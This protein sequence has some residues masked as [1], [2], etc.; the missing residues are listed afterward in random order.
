[1][2]NR[3]PRRS[4]SD[5]KDKPKPGFPLSIDVEKSRA[6]YGM[7]INRPMSPAYKAASPSHKVDVPHGVESGTD[8]SDG[9]H[10]PSAKERT[11]TLSLPSKDK[12]AK[13]RRR[14]VQL[15]PNTKQSPFQEEPGETSLLSSAG[16]VDSEDESSPVERMSRS[17]FIAPA[18]PAIRFSVSGN[19]FQELLSQVDPRNRSSLNVIK[20][21]V[22]IG[23]NGGASQSTLNLRGN[24]AQDEGRGSS[25]PASALTPTFGSSPI[26][27]NSSA[28][29][30][31]APSSQG[32]SD[33][34]MIL[35]PPETTKD[36]ESEL[37][38][39]QRGTRNAL[40]S[41]SSRSSSERSRDSPANDYQH[42]RSDSNTAAYHTDASSSEP[43]PYF[44][45][46]APDSSVARPA[47]LD[48]SYGVAKRL[49]DALQD[50][51][52]RGLTHVTLDQEF[53]QTVV[54]MVEQRR[55]EN[56]VMKGR[57]DHIKSPSQ[58]TMDGLT[59]AYSEYDA[60]L[61]ARREAEA[62]VSRLRVLLSGQ[63]ARITALSGQGRRDELH[64]QLSLNLKDDLSALEQD[65]AKLKVERDV[66]LVEMEEIASCKSSGPATDKDVASLN[67]SLSTRL[68][69]LKVQYKGELVSLTD[70]RESLLREIAE[71]QSAREIFLEE[72]TMLNARNEELAQLN[73]YYMRRIEAA[74]SESPM[75]G[76]E[77]H[78]SERQHPV[79]PL[80]P[81][82]TVN[83]SFGASSDEGADSIKSSKCQ[84]KHAAGVFKWRGNSK[85]AAAL[86]SAVQDGTNEKPV[87]KHLFQ[88]VSVLRL[89]KCDHCAEKLWGSQARCQTCHISVHPRCHQNVQVI[90]VPQNSRREEGS[91]PGVLQPAMFGREL[92]EQLRTDSKFNEKMVPLI[93]EKCIAAVDASGLDYE[94]I[95]RKNGGTGQSKLITQLFERGDYSTFDLLDSERFNDISSITSVLKSYFRSLPNPL[96]TF[97]L[98][99]EFIFAAS[100]Q[101][102]IHKCAKYA[103]LVMQLPTEHYYTL[104]ALMLHLHR[105]QEHHE[106]NLMTARNLGVVFGP[107]LMRS[108]VPGAEF[109]DMAG[110]ALTIEWL[111]ENAPTI[112]PPS[113]T[114]HY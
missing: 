54:M 93:V 34:F 64:R 80:Q 74:S 52:R 106:E 68:D 112:F 7:G 79:L 16:D 2:K 5:D 17:T 104:R 76:R 21:L 20:E 46:T 77:K 61:K 72:T 85:E 48:L 32:H 33:S 107:T 81:S 99:D 55:D 90:C 60:E 96:L 23:Q 75:P 8:T 66:A 100:I 37:L 30:I 13:S 12:E 19:G 86:A 92:T 50:A 78:S 25:T 71:L 3:A 38:L 24:A 114:S 10:E 51:V 56:A 69:Y 82:H 94:G 1:M 18:H 88:Q 63:A 43:S 95:Y 22:K 105:V 67:R 91:T 47:K 45:V 40:L 87:R 84:P 57:P 102:P 26:A 89:S 111:V 83:S 44:T 70:G 14:T 28:T 62:E 101:D 15:G 36:A 65:V 29:T 58:Q 49:Q 73:A 98:H 53:V 4:T 97:A 35:D 42:A 103:D 59:V 110:K 109:A 113:S 39:H 6:G 11:Q 31:S 108:R 27:D 9:E 41:P